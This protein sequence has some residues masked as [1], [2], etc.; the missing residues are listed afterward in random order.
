M[1]N[2]S[3]FVSFCAL[4][5]KKV[6]PIIDRMQSMGVSL[7]VNSTLMSSG[8]YYEEVAKS[9]LSSSKILVFLSEAYLDTPV[10]SELS[11]ALKK[12]K[13]IV[14]VFLEETE[15]PPGI[16]FQLTNK[17][18]INRYLFDS[19]SSFIEALL[20][21]SYL[22]I[23][24]EDKPDIKYTLTDITAAELDIEDYSYYD[25]TESEYH[26]VLVLKNLSGKPI[27]IDSGVEFNY[28]DEQ[29]NGAL[30]FD[31]ADNFTTGTILDGEKAVLHFVN[32]YPPEES[33]PQVLCQLISKPFPGCESAA[34]YI[35][36]KITPCG[37]DI[38]LTMKN[39]SD[40]ELWNL[41]YT[42]LFFKGE[43]LV[44]VDAY[45]PDNDRLE[46][47][48]STEAQI[49]TGKENLLYD[50]TEAYFTGNI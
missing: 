39:T 6:Y 23:A 13:D 49:L 14:A 47:G 42:V 34:S 21:A 8:D 48:D 4:D 41:E 5:S 2:K 16:D 31:N 10:L 27:K 35:D 3:V 50:R 37:D 26:L 32:S 29:G 46:P 28:Y 12:K 1:N 33:C 45:Y 18:C 24:K 38:F 30:V 44:A 25:E 9:I 22:N 43:K 36:W 11:Y 7:T 17:P 40:C 19:D 20:S 15:L